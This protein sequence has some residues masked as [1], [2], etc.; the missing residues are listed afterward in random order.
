MIRA[1]TFANIQ[2]SVCLAKNK[3]RVKKMNII[4]LRGRYDNEPIVIRIEA[5][6]SIKKCIDSDH[7][8]DEYSSVAVG[9][10][11]FDVNE[12]IDII[13]RKIN[14]AEK[15]GRTAAYENERR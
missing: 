3:R 7:N 12:P 8:K 10:M 14:S 6:S 1:V 13:M 11:F 4:V 9:N 15:K 2:A 5:I